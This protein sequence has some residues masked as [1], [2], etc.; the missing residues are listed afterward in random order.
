MLKVHC[1][2]LWPL[3]TVLQAVH[4]FI[5]EFQTI[6][7]EVPITWQFLDDGHA[8]PGLLPPL[9]PMATLSQ[10]HYLAMLESLVP[11]PTTQN[12]KT[13][14]HNSNLSMEPTSS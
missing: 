9:A 10:L 1:V 12:Q 13:Y 6:K 2:I 14:I 4:M 11:R 8:P 7:S 3:I 5:Q